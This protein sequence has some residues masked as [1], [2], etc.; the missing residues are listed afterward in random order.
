VSFLVQLATFFLI[1]LGYWA[2]GDAAWTI[3][4]N[5]VI[6]PLLIV[7]MTVLAFGVGVLVAALTTR[8][9]D[10]GFLLGFGI[11]LL[12]Y[13]SPVIFPLSL[14]PEGSTLRTVILI[15]PMAGIIEGFRAALLGTPMDLGL[16]PYS[17]GAA[18]VMLLVGTMVFQRVQRSFADVI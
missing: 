10:L 17:A 9:R 11:Q 5:I 2:F 16:L 3:G 4:P 8:F 6:L 1:A 15:N 12:M 7:I 13:G 14:V 18:V